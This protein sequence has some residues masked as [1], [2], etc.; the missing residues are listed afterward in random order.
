M[1]GIAGLYQV[2]K[3]TVHAEAIAPMVE[4][5]KHRAPDGCSIWREGAVALAQL[6]MHT[7]PAVAG[8][9]S[10]L[11]SRDGM[12]VLV[13]DARI[14]NREELFS[15]LALT[16][17][18]RRTVS[19]AALIL[20]SYALWGTRCVD[21]LIGAFA[22]ALWDAHESHIFCARDHAG[23]RP[24]YYYVDGQRFAFASE[25][26]GVLAHPDITGTA[27][28]ERIADFLSHVHLSD[29]YTF[30]REVLRLPAG[31]C[32]VV[33]T[34]GLTKRRYWEWQ[35]PE[36]L[37]L[38]SPEAYQERFRSI[39]G[40]AVRCRLRGE[41]GVGS[42]LSGGLDSSGITTM[43]AKLSAEPL[44]T[45]SAVFD[46][47]S[48]SDERR[49]IQAVVDGSNCAPTFVDGHDHDPIRDLSYLASRTGKP[50]IGLSPSLLWMLYG[51]V[52]DTGLTTV[53]DGHGGDEVLSKGH[54]YINELASNRRWWALAREIIGVSRQE[55]GNWLKFFLL[56]WLRFGR[57]PARVARRLRRLI[58]SIGDT[59]E[60]NMAPIE[61]VAEAFASRT[62]AAER[63]REA[64]RSMYG[65]ATEREQHLTILSHS[66]QVEALEE[67]NQLGHLRGVE[68]RVPY[69]D[70]RL[71]K[72]CLSLP[73][74][75]KYTRGVGRQILRK[76]LKGMLPDIIATRRDKAIF[77]SP[78]A[79]AL[80]NAEVGVSPA[81]S[82][83]LP[84]VM[85]YVD[86]EKV[87][88]VTETFVETDKRTGGRELVAIMEVLKLGY[89]LKDI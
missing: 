48:D 80:G 19:D 58:R 52:S 25:V 32:A 24:F 55:G 5:Q 76:S 61:L 17:E 46:Q 8:Q 4:A 33:N 2:D 39:F 38:P 14:D 71:V 84:F 3:A 75:V 72:F 44:P 16:G 85:P 29:E 73:T 66:L 70:I 45:F 51:S 54:G 56:Y 36:Q 63:Q 7:I 12:M 22:F 43:A 50:S 59:S 60:M 11:V 35:L 1:P 83:L 42:L 41:G 87:H 62:N 26:N 78:V 82:V 34:S 88:R 86:A 6:Q 89:W 47:S 30:Y 31:H 64:M 79:L 15:A 13:S 69:W 67:L 81:V 20:R 37:N 57:V 27:N 68:P 23:V 49:Y 9:E 28:E 77:N 10:P 74:E 65:A 40:E 18:D 21:H 53:L